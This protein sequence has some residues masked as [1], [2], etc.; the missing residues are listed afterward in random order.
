MTSVI[1]Y[2]T[3]IAWLYMCVCACVRACVY[4]TDDESIKWNAAVLD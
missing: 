3:Y 2:I 1:V 4:I